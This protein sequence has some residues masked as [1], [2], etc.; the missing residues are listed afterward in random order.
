MRKQELK[1]AATSHDG[2]LCSEHSS[3]GR[4]RFD[5]AAGFGKI[6]DT[7]LKVRS[8]SGLLILVPMQLMNHHF[9]IH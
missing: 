9:W 4:S 5:I 1:L 7:C 6:T 2:T 3:V 8:V